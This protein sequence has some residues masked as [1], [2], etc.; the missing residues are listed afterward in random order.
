MTK[1]KQGRDGPGADP[2]YESAM[3][4]QALD[5]DFPVIDILTP[6]LGLFFLVLPPFKSFYLRFGHNAFL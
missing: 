1:I 4:L 5:S 3:V 6:I 2:S